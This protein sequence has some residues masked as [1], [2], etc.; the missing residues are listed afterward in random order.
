MGELYE[1]LKSY[2]ESDYYPYHMPGH[3]RRLGGGVLSAVSRLDITEIDGFDNLHEPNEI[4]KRI[5]Q[6]AALIYGAEESFYLVNGSTAGI[7]S[8]VS[9]AVQEGGKILMARG[10][11]RAAYHGAYLRGLDIRYLVAET[12]PDFGCNLGITSTQVEQALMEEPDIQAVLLV[13]P[14][15]EGIVSDI[16]QIAGIVHKRGIPLI[17]D[18]AHGAHLGFHSAWPKSSCRCGADIV[19][20]SLHK[21]LPSP[22]QT[23]ILH[24]NGKLVDR[25]RIKRFLGIYQSSS[26]SYLFMAAMEEALDLTVRDADRLFGDFLINWKRM[27]ERLNGCRCLQVLQIEGM[28]IGKLVIADKSGH[29]TGRQ[30]YDSLLQ[31]YHLQPEMAVGNYV[32]AMFTVGD[33]EEGYYRMTEALLAIDAEIY[34]QCGICA[35]NT[36]HGESEECKVSKLSKLL[37]QPPRALSLKEAWEKEGEKIP[38]AEATGRLAGEFINLYPPGI[39]ILVPGECFTEELCSYIQDCMDK[40]LQ[41]QGIGQDITVKVL[42]R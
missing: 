8:A 9:A 17:V 34:R 31:N 23:A 33:T 6:K 21:T 16:E 24:V 12:D 7:L 30:L 37:K 20:Q 42:K 38:L 39:P 18:E 4:I 26:P 40:G 11:H 32:L 22:T 35:D 14:T 29:M 36:V 27:L 41:V 2:A 1:K 15:Y 3:K 5:Q 25:Q 19:V 13:S 10:C 28:D